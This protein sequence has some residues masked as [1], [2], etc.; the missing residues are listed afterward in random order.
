MNTKGEK[1][2]K[3]TLILEDG[4]MFPGQAFGDV[5]KSTAGEVVFATGMTGYAESLTDPSYCGQIIVMTY[6]LI[7]NY[8]VSKLHNDP[9]ILQADFESWKIH[10]SGLVVSSIIHTP[11]HYRS[12]LSLHEWMSREHI[13]GITGVD[14]RAITQHLR[15]YGTMKGHISV[16]NGIVSAREHLP[17]EVAHVS[18]PTLHRY[19]NGK[20]ANHA[21]RRSGRNIVLIDCGVKHGI[22]RE[23]VSRGSNVLRVPWDYPVSTLRDIDGVV[24]SNGPGDP[25]NADKTIDEV[26]R[27]IARRVPV[28]GI[29]LGHQIIALALG[30]QTYKLPYGHRGHNQPVVDLFTGRAYITSQNH[31]YG[32]KESTLPRNVLPWFRSLNDQT[33]EGFR[34][35]TRPILA[36]QFHPEA[37]P[38]PTDTNFL[39]DE[40]M[41]LTS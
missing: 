32:V 21:R 5:R 33:N 22:I 11:S 37:C 20:L 15:E 1:H 23:L 12:Q 36:V 10:A 2:P 28:W 24:I 25:L 6:P 27:L 38:G 19:G 4:M 30:A 3:A 40:F 29:C 35:R 17:H 14:T 34:H 31:G 26:R 18:S 13:L 8:G 9:R 16:G 7:G 41:K 39:F